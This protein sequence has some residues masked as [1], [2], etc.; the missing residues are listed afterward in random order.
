MGVLLALIV[1]VVVG[2]IAY[3]ITKEIDYTSRYARA[4][5]LIVAVLVFLAQ[6]GYGV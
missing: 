2:G 6:Y 1:A 5:G 4:I 3:L